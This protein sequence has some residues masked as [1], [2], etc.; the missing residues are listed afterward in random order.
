MKKILC[1]VLIAISAFSGR[2]VDDKFF[3]ALAAVE[4][5]GNPRA[6][7]KAESAVGIFQIRKSYF[8]DAVAFNKNLSKYSHSDCFRADISRLVVLAYMNRYAKEAVKSNNYEVLAKTHNGGSG[9]KK[10]TGQVKNNLNI[11]WNKLKK[12][13]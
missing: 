5:G 11:Y 6:Y 2:C 4:S 9:W 13:L 3:K 12:F 1:L 10:K 7:N 8:E